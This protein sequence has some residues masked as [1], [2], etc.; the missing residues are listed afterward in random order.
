[1]KVA[2][3]LLHEDEKHDF[4]VDKFL[5]ELRQ[6]TSKFLAV[7]PPEGNDLIR[8][9]TPAVAALLAKSTTLLDPPTLERFALLAAFAPTPATFSLD[10]LASVWE[11]TDAADTA[12]ALV[13]KGLLE[14]AD[15]GRFHL[16]SLLVAHAR[17][18]CEE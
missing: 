6:N 9:A 11:A 13:S 14:Q 10:D 5:N 15:N 4:R 7:L 3:R 17:T 12:R 18:L 8:T 2:G 1:M 16:H